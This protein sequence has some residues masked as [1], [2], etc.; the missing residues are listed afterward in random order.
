MSLKGAGKKNN[1]IQNQPPEKQKTNFD[2]KSRLLIMEDS[3]SLQ[4]ASPT[5]EKP[6]ED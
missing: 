4:Q 5:Q 6:F 1:A 2:R 3:F